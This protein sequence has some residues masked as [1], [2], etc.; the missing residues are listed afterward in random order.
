M[1]KWIAGLLGGGGVPAGWNRIAHLAIA[2]DSGRWRINLDLNAGL[3]YVK[4]KSPLV[5]IL[6]Y[7][8]TLEFEDGRIQD[9]SVGRLLAGTESRPMA[10]AGRRLKGMAVEYSLASGVRRGRLESWARC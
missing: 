3:R 4:L 7:R 1:T 9:L 2:G 8:W 6:V 5:D 10:I